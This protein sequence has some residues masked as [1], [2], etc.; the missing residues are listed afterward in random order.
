MYY[1][2]EKQSPRYRQ[3]DLDEFWWGESASTLIT[4]NQTNTVVR[5]AEQIPQRIAWSCGSSRRLYAALG[6]F[7]AAN[8]LLL[9]TDLHTQYSTFRIPKA[10]GGFR[11]IDAPK[12]MLKSAQYALKALLEGVFHAHEL[13]HTSAIG[14]VKGRRAADAGRRHQQN[15]SWWFCNTDFKDFFPSTTLDFV[16]AQFSKIFPFCLL[17][18]FPD[19]FDRLRR[20]LS[21]VFLDGKLPQGTPVSPLITN[22]MMVPIDFEL[23][24]TLRNYKGKSFVYTRYA[25]DIQIS[26]KYD[27]EQRDI[28][29]LIVQVLRKHNAPFTL[30]ADKTKYHSKSGSNWILGVVLNKDNRIT[31]GYKNLRMF[32]SILYNFHRDSAAGLPWDPGDIQHALGLWSYYR[33]V[34]RETI[35]ATV[36][37]YQ[38]KYGENIIEAMRAAL[39]V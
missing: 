27:F 12:P 1:Y 29:E 26:C 3:M 35:D 10:H 15:E 37:A 22:V 38:E 5:C 2:V 11:R 19:G 4:E 17:E 8:V 34:D 23:C 21:L 33:S 14:Y 24:N 18:N 31:V 28:E 39:S 20:A 30:N 36:A 25:D 6:E 13:Y 32:K 9:D 16:M 7:N